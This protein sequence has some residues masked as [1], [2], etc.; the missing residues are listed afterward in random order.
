MTELQSDTCHLLGNLSDVPEASKPV[1]KH[2][3]GHLGSCLCAA[4]RKMNIMTSTETTTLSV[5]SRPW[6]AHE[7]RAPLMEHQDEE[8][9][10]WYVLTLSS[11]RKRKNV[12]ALRGRWPRHLRRHGCV[13]PYIWVCACAPRAPSLFSPPS[14]SSDLWPSVMLHDGCS[15]C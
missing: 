6:L 10:G 9:E 2:L 7:Q 8:E 12:A 5:H 1:G 4:V 11:R 14:V 13:S 15:C 3:P